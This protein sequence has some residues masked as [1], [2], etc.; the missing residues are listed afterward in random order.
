MVIVTETNN[1]PDKSKTK[2]RLSAFQTG[3]STLKER[4]KGAEH[5]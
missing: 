3:I 2:E 1:T 4:R 5:R